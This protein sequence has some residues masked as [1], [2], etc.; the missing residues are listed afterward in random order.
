MTSSADVALEVASRTIGRL[1]NDGVQPHQIVILTNDEC[2]APVN[3]NSLK[4]GNVKIEPMGEFFKLESSS[5]RYTTINRFKGLEADAVI[6]LDQPVMSTARRLDFYTS[7]TRAI[8]YLAVLRRGS[9]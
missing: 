9:A 3:L 1:I 5:I 7:A 2:E 6:I 8:S 4:V